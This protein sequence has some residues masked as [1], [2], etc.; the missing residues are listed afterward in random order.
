MLQ[1][2]EMIEIAQGIIDTEIQGLEKLKQS[3]G[4]EF[5]RAVESIYGMKGK[6]VIT[7]IGKTGAV[8]KKMAATLASTGT[9]TIFMNSTEG[10]HG[11]LGMVNPEDIVIAI[12]NSGESDE[13]LNILPAIKNIGAKIF[14]MTG[15]IQSR[16]AKAADLVL[17][18]GVE[19]EGCPLNLAPMASTTAAIALGDALAGVLMRVRNFQPQNFAM[20]HP[21]GSLGRKLL[22]SVKNLMKT[23]EQLAICSPDTRMKDIILAMNEKRL[24]ILCV[25]VVEELKGIITEGDIRRAL[26]REEEFFNLRAEDIMTR[27]YK[28]IT[29][30][31]MANE[32]L[33][34]MEEGEYQIS[35]LPVFHEGHFVGVLRIHDLLKLK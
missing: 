31:M 30:E 18:C 4:K 29:Q 28:S 32:A 9:T 11:D 7:G 10:L 16:L 12:S 21:G 22:S 3:F 20:Y 2:K 34:H 17:F 1:E 25:M 13:I 8:G 24:G 14:A 35:V 33:S 26:S 6:I 27:K 15:N 5:I 23:G 19:T